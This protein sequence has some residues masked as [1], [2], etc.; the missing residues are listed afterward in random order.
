MGRG[1]GRVG[2]GRKST[3]AHGTN[4]QDDRR[5]EGRV[6][7]LNWQSKVSSVCSVPGKQPKDGKKPEPCKPIL[8][9]EYKTTR[10]G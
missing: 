2:G 8:K 9:V 6:R 1:M 10:S 7:G 4:K 5:V 3:H